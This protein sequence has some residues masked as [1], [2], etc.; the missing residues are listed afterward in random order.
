MSKVNVLEIKANDMVEFSDSRVQ[1]YSNGGNK[2]S[3]LVKSVTKQ[4]LGAIESRYILLYNNTG[5]YVTL[6]D[7]VVRKVI[8]DEERSSYMAQMKLRSLPRVINVQGSD[9]EIFIVD[10][11]NVVIPSFLFL[12]GKDSPNRIPENNEAIFW[13]GF[14]AEFNVKADSCLDRTVINTYYGL[15]ELNRLAKLHDKNARLTIIP[16]MDIP[17]HMLQENKEEH[18]Q[19]GCMPSKNAYGM[20]G[21]N[22]DGRDVPFRSAGGHIHLQLT[23][24]QK[25]RIEQ[26]VKALDA[27]LGVACVSMFGAFDDSRRREYYGLA[28]EYRTPAHGMEYRP[29]SNVWMCH[30]TAMYIVYDLARKVISLVDQGLFNVWKYDEKEVIDCINTCNIPLACEILKI[31]EIAFKDILHS[32]CYQRQDTVDVVYNTFMLGIENLI[33]DVD[34]IEK[35]WNLSGPSVTT[36]GR[37]EKLKIKNPQFNKLLEFKW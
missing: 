31:N 4:M 10:K 30:P 18:V 33:P 9:P 23:S 25:K 15:K 37:I 3:G 11:N 12:K 2:F 17:P 8:T 24:E 32:I 29:L 5:G 14:Q 28:G 7:E 13:D 26:Y 16:T 22:V 20:K 1:H 27:I 19:F 36:D 6:T 21:P 35:N 34:N